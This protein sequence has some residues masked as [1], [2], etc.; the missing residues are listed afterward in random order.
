MEGFTSTERVPGN[1]AVVVVAISQRSAG[2]VAIVYA[3]VD[4]PLRTETVCA[5]GRFAPICQ[6]KLS[7]LG[8]A[9]GAEACAYISPVRAER[10]AAAMI[11]DR[12]IAFI[13]S[14]FAYGV[15]VDVGDGAGV[16]LPGVSGGSPCRALAM[17][18]T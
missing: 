13:S 10:T 1:A 17:L 6:T 2:G 3:A 18:S 12:F 16:V 9:V 14:K 5:A 8:V 11:R 4:V 7:V 15:G